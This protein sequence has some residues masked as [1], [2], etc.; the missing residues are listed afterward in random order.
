MRISRLTENEPLPALITPDGERDLLR[1]ARADRAG[2]RRLTREHGAVLFRGF[3]VETPGQFGEICA[4]LTDELLDYT[5]RSTPRNQVEG[6]VYTSTEYPPAA[7]IPLHCEMAYTTKWPRLLWMY[8]HVA[9][10]E[11]GE[12]P[13]CD[14][15]KVHEL[16][17]PATR[18]RLDR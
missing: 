10:E 14:A 4:A 5:E 6:K 16:I 8:S 15:R 13:I 9:A 17:S 11:G 2:V 18:Q 12:T 1:V 7:H 3:A